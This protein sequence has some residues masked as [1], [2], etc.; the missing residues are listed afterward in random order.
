MLYYLCV[1]VFICGYSR[2]DGLPSSSSERLRQDLAVG[3]DRP[4]AALAVGEELGRV[5]AHQVV[6]CRQDVLR[7][8]PAF[9]RVAGDPV[10]LADDP[11]AG[12]AAAGHDDG[13]APRPVIA[14][15]SRDGRGDPRRPTVLAQQDD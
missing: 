15:A 7:A 13:V 2:I 11:A 10:G 14:A 1:S 4:G 6:D 5:D 8:D 3:D 9:D 12:D